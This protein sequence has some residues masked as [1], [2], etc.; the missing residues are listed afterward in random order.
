MLLLGFTGSVATVLGIKLIKAM[1]EIDPDV[2]VVMTERARHF[3][4]CKEV[5]DAGATVCIEEDEWVWKKDG[6]LTTRWTKDDK[7]LHIE[8]RDKASRMVIAPCSA[9]TMGKIANGICDNLLTSI[10][11]AWD[12]SKPL[13]IAPAMNTKMWWHPITEKHIATLKEFGYQIIPPQTKLLACGEMGMGALANIDVIA[14][15]VK[16]RSWLFPLSKHFA[17]GIPL[18]PHPGAFGYARKGSRHTGI[19][20]YSSEPHAGVYAVEDGTVV[21]VEHFTGEWDNS[22]WWNNTDCILVEGASGVICYGEIVT[23]LKPGDKVEA[24]QH[25][26]NIVQV[27]KDGREHPEIPGHSKNMLHLELYP[28]GTTR[29]SAGFESH[30]RDPTPFVLNSFN[31][32][33]TIPLLVYDGYKPKG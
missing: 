10:V 6:H 11:R 16:Y 28:S 9:N 5:C 14:N 25:I 30:L 8:L 18:N 19:D 3:I 21:C 7:V 26:A 32:T 31:G 13:Y 27:I 1:Q 24:G 2:C 22:P 33:P 15:K 17:K 20:L 23:N 29:P 12:T 4:T